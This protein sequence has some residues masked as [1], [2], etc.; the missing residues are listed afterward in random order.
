MPR[1]SVQQVVLLM[2]M[3]ANDFITRFGSFAREV[4]VLNFVKILD[5]I[6]D[7][8][9]GIRDELRQ[10]YE[11]WLELGKG[12]TYYINSYFKNILTGVP[13]ADLDRIFD[14]IS[15]S[16]H[17]PAHADTEMKKRMFD[18]IV[19]RLA[20][21]SGSRAAA[22]CE[23]IQELSKPLA[24]INSKY[25]ASDAFHSLL[26]AAQSFPG[27]P[28]KWATGSAKISWSDA[29][30]ANAGK[31]FETFIDAI[32]AVLQ[33]IE[34]VKV[35]ESITP[36]LI[37][38]RLLTGIKT[39]S[40]DELLPLAKYY[41]KLGVPA[42][43]RQI[44]DQ[45]I[46]FVDNEAFQR[47]G[48]AP[49]TTKVRSF[50][51]LVDQFVSARM[52]GSKPLTAF[53][54][55]VEGIFERMRKNLTLMAKG[56][57]GLSPEDQA[58]IVDIVWLTRSITQNE[59]AYHV[60]EQQSWKLAE[61]LRGIAKNDPNVGET[62]LKT[63]ED[64][65]IAGI[66]DNTWMGLDSITNIKNKVE[67]KQELWKLRDDPE[68]SAAINDLITLSVVLKFMPSNMFYHS[69]DKLGPT[70]VKSS[71]DR[72]SNIIM[73]M[74]KHD[75]KSFMDDD[76]QYDRVCAAWQATPASEQKTLVKRA[77]ES[78]KS[79][80]QKF[81]KDS[82]ELKKKIPPEAPKSGVLDQY[83][84]ADHRH[85]KTPHEPD[86]EKERELYN[87]L[88]AHFAHNNP[89]SKKFADQLAVFIKKGQYD[90]IIREPKQKWIYRGMGV[91]E[92][93]IRKSLKMKPDQVMSPKGH[94]IAWFT[95]T[96]KG[97]AGGTSWTINAE[98]AKNFTSSETYRLIMVASTTRNE[99]KFVL[100]P[101][102]LYDVEGLDTFTDEEEAIGLGEIKVSKIFWQKMSSGGGLE[103]PQQYKKKSKSS[104]GGHPSMK[105]K[106]KSKKPL[107]KKPGIKPG[108]FYKKP[109]PKKPTKKSSKKK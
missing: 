90:K 70:D 14:E 25:C 43:W 15:K 36:E 20:A 53:I 45:A 108:I 30:S 41:Q 34:A 38:Q 46:D 67:E 68:F 22:A 51:G 91:S 3:T 81:N 5:N 52:L 48:Y 11:D 57:A 82:A 16:V 79:W 60:I 74:S 103:I 12:D 98:K 23:N 42:T 87:A 26:S 71:E 94:K 69:F 77:A 109:P 100:G 72:W 96:P 1:A 6:T 8:P 102:G 7:E 85:G 18:E 107:P 2:E 31:K 17:V 61:I 73:S 56:A 63:I 89:M 54:T 24:N 93:F 49:P 76:W 40:T 37:A 33:N 104:K 101:G 106:P 62:S 58:A 39:F 97:S 28:K 19:K 84:F 9:A 59:K 105:V 21:L 50:E 32:E 35:D 86:N 44:I 66:I 10:A 13:S 95:F 80:V 27:N 29:C 88:R 92:S 99:Q 55:E 4:K 75:K 78:V 83:A 65:V 64:Y 47:G